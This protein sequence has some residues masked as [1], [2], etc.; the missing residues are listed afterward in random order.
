MKLESTGE[1]VKF[2]KKKKRPEVENII[3][4]PVT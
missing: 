4:V 3:K 2:L 1:H